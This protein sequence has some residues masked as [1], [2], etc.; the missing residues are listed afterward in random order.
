[1]TEINSVLFKNLCSAFAAEAA[2]VL[3]FTN[4]AQV[5][6]IEG[7]LGTA[8]AFSELAESAAC[9]AHGHIDF[10]RAMADPS[11][12]LPIGDTGLNVA[13]AVASEAHAATV[14]YPALARDAHAE[15]LADMASWMETLVALKQ[16]HLVRL[17]QLNQTACAVPDEGAAT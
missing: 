12:E 16:V 10:L 11:T 3:R 8:R 4:F 14:L 2:T 13:A 15:G 17:N 1:M 6:E 7:S 9:V 5:A